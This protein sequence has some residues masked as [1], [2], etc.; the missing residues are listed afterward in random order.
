MFYNKYTSY[1]TL[2]IIKCNCSLTSLLVFTKDIWPFATVYVS[3]FLAHLYAMSYLPPLARWKG[4][5]MKAYFSALKKSTSTQEINNTFDPSLTPLH[6]IPAV[7]QQTW[8]QTEQIRPTFPERTCLCLP[9]CSSMTSALWGKVRAFSS[10]RMF[11]HILQRHIWLEVISY[12]C[13]YCYTFL[14]KKSGLNRC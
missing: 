4:T 11:R 3:I 10:A 14:R 2:F 5:L 7:N 12:Y 9:T 8:R 6:V 13:L 1:P